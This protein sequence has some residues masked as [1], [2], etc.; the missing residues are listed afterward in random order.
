MRTAFS[1][2][3]MLVAVLCSPLLADDG[4][5]KIASEVDAEIQVSIGILEVSRQSLTQLGFDLSQKRP[6]QQ[7]PLTA[8]E[9][10]S[11]LTEL[12]TSK[13]L[14]QFAEPSLLVS[15]NKQAKYFSGG[16]VTIGQELFEVGTRV[17]MTATRQE[18]GGL[19][20][21][22]YVS[23]VEIL[24]PKTRFLGTKKLPIVSRH[25]MKG[26]VVVSDKRPVFVI[27]AA[28][29]DQNRILMVAFQVEE[30]QKSSNVPSDSNGQSSGVK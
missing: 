29:P 2:M 14:K 28:A 20:L 4:A 1:K 30:L 9:F 27:P 18:D 15:L 6:D 24:Q 12:K 3:L 19:N 10:K 26:N 23:N 16:E 7:S 25:R 11:M 22:W 17:E 13:D 21:R 5:G 8:T